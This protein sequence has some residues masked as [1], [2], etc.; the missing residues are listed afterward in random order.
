MGATDVQESAGRW[1]GELLERIQH[2]FEAAVPKPVECLASI[3]LVNAVGTRVVSDG[4]RQG[5]C[6]KAAL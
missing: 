4:R 2:A 1:N 6:E 5:G 3:C